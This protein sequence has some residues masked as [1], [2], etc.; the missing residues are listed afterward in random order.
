MSDDGPAGQSEVLEAGNTGEEDDEEIVIRVDLVGRPE[1][2]TNGTA[3]PIAT[4][5]VVPDE[6]LG[7]TAEDASDSEATPAPTDPVEADAT[8]TVP[9]KKETSRSGVKALP[10]NHFFHKECLQPWFQ[11]KHTW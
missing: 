8:S 7:E 5:P 1:I 10:C 6:T 11:T 3:T 4:M 2:S 9:P